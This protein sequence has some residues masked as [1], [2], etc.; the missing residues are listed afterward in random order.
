[1]WAIEFEE[2][3]GGSRTWRLL[4][5]IQPGLF[6]QLVVV[7]F[8]RDHRILYPAAVLRGHRAMSDTLVRRL[9]RRSGSAGALR[10]VRSG[11]RRV[12]CA[13][14]LAVEEATSRDISCECDGRPLDRSGVLPGR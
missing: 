8:F 11:A 13:P 5:G 4:E 2:A 1:M 10:S 6:S 12:S 3:E 14:T 9:Q 7:A